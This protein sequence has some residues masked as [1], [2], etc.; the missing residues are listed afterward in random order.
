VAN[1]GQE[2]V[3]AVK[4]SYYDAVLM[5]IQMPVMDGYEA[6]RR[7]RKWESGM[8][9]VEVGMRNAECGRKSEVGMRKAET[10]DSGQRTT[11]LSS[12]DGFAVAGK[13]QQPE[14]RVRKTDN[15]TQA[16]NLQP[17]TP[18]IPIIAM[19]ANA[20][21]GD[22]EKSLEAGMNDHVAK[23]IDTKELFSTLA[24]DRAR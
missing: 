10:E 6:T 21:A 19:T 7:I 16:S 9:N 12:P 2:A 18:N 15:G 23:P 17:P 13:D 24:K 8:R 5:D 4:D 22:R 11:D 3:D 14:N 20:M 1:D